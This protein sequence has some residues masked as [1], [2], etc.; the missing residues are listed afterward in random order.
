MAALPEPDDI[1]REFLNYQLKCF[2]EEGAAL[3]GQDSEIW[4]QLGYDPDLV[5][6]RGRPRL[7]PFAR[8]LNNIAR[9]LASKYGYNSLDDLGLLE[10]DG[11]RVEKIASIVTGV[12]ASLLPVVA[13]TVLY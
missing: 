1:D 6:L 2:A 3:T 8:W 13:I 9:P 10:Y 7:D 4:R 12:L 5:A 11:R